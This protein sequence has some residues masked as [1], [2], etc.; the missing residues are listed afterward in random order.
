MMRS[1]IRQPQSNFST[2]ADK[3]KEE[4]ARGKV[5]HHL[6]AQSSNS[7]TLKSA[8]ALPAVIFFPWSGVAHQRQPDKNCQ[9]HIEEIIFW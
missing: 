4:L 1:D 6:V 2:L 5:Q 9:S 8:E 3:Q 7:R